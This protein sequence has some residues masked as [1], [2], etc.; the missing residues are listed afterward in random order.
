MSSRGRAWHGLTL[1]AATAAL[2]LQLALVIRGHAVLA[3]TEPPALGTRLV[4]FV[5]YF[6]ILSNG[7]VALTCFQLLAG[8]F[9]GR[10]FRVLRLNAITGIAVTGLVHW[11]LLRPLLDLHGLDALADTLL[12]IVVPVM[13]VGGWLV[14]G[15]RGLVHHSDLAP[16]AIYPGLYLAWSLV[17][18]AITHWYPYPFVDVTT[19]GYVTV[20]FNAIAVVALLIGLSYGAVAL[21]EQLRR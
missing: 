10:V 18:G 12:H 8:W 21:D 16:S 4:R 17:H 5:S 13:A 19:H 11:F 7:L 2:L 15:P 20:L 3:D 9:H 6:T 1:A 14:V